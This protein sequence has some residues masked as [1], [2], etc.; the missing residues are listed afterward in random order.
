MMKLAVSA[1]LAGATIFSGA[2]N[3]QTITEGQ[4][5]AN[6]SFE[7]FDATGR[8][9]IDMGQM[10]EVGESIFLSMDTDENGRISRSEMLSWDF[11]FVNIAASADR[12]V[13]YD[14]ALKVVHSF[15]DRNGDAEVDRSESRQ[16]A[17][18]DFRRAD[19]DDNAVLS[20]E[21][22]IGGFSVMVALR[23]ALKPDD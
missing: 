14:T 7:M 22:F 3:A 16:S 2:A 1:L 21:E 23:A 5:L 10:L 12:Q 15:W 13:A 6:L 17:I 19:V 20:R 11:G 8:G 9:Y 4:R 18:A